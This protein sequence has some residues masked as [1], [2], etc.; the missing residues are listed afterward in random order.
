MGMQ[1]WPEGT[2][3]VELPAEP[4]TSAELHDVVRYVEDR[5]DCDVVLDFGKVTIVASNSLAPLLRLRDLM[6]YH[7]RR[8]LLSGVGPSTRGIFSITALDG[9]FDI[10]GHRVD[11]LVTVQALPDSPIEP[12]A[13]TSHATE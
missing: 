7:G 5:G 3:L 11:A 9:V 4:E 13:S 10:V 8:L 6:R 1:I 2:V 12:A